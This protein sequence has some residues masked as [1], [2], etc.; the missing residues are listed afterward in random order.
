[1]NTTFSLYISC[2]NSE[3]KALDIRFDTSVVLECP[4]CSVHIPISCKDY[5]NKSIVTFL[6]TIRGERP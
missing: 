5:R 6:P 3:R 2:P 1:M 4:V